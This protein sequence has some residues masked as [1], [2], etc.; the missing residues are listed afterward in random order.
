MHCL[1]ALFLADVF[2]NCHTALFNKQK[3]IVD[4][5][6]GQKLSQHNSLIIPKVITET[7]CCQNVIITYLT[8]NVSGTLINSTMACMWMVTIA[9]DKTIQNI[10]FVFST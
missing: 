1:L 4:S 5:Y 2:N 10:P 3:L 8:T 7:M 9:D 6:L